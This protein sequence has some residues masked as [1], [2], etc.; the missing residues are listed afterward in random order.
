M[1]NY[2]LSKNYRNITG[3]GNKAKTDMEKIL[4]DLGYKNAGLT[5]TVC[6]NKVIGFILT[7]IG[8]C[9]VFFKISANDTVIIQ[10]PF[11]KHYAFVCNII[12]LKKGKVITLIHDLGVFRRKR[13]SVDKEIKL[14]DHSD[15]DRKSVV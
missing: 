15:I 12:H 5:Q 11:K 8:V 6:S 14:L 2:Y 3:A 13:L 10:Y 7:L 4:S 9:S 1:G